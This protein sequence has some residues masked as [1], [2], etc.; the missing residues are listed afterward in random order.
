MGYCGNCGTKLDDG[1]K[2]C[3]ECGK[4][5]YAGAERNTEQN[6]TLES[7][8][9]CP[10]CG[11]DKVMSRQR[12]WSWDRAFGTAIMTFVTLWFVVF[13]L[14]SFWCIVVVWLYFFLCV[15]HADG[16]CGKLPVAERWFVVIVLPP[17]RVMR[18]NKR[19]YSF[20]C[21]LLRR[22]SLLS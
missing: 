3:P 2:F 12:G 8:I 13:A 1:V 18:S 11:C 6:S 14:L 19:L 16:F 22:R 10:K 9:K 21:E 15:A 5:V 17:Q 7:M 4:A 20:R